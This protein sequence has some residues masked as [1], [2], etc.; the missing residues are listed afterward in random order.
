MKPKNSPTSTV[1][2][3]D[4]KGSDLK[5]KKSKNADISNNNET[6]N[7][8]ITI[9]SSEVKVKKRENSK[10]IQ[11]MKHFRHSLPAFVNVSETFNNIMGRPRQGSPNNFE[12]GLQPSEAWGL[13]D[14]RNNN[15]LART[16][17][18]ASYNGDYR[19]NYLG[20]K[21]K[22]SDIQRDGSFSSNRSVSPCIN[23]EPITLKVS[24]ENSETDTE[25]SIDPR[26]CS[27]LSSVQSQESESLV[28]SPTDSPPRSPE[29]PLR[30]SRNRSLAI[31]KRSNVVVRNGKI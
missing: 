7:N 10:R 2:L 27:S 17:S 26:S 15:G 4:H 6:D 19:S 31:R 28:I 23:E 12:T 21:P 1:E 3:E 11:S 29:L 9:P 14:A 30:L 16:M 22:S 24:P 25:C 5:S 13:G 8:I 18:T 20:L